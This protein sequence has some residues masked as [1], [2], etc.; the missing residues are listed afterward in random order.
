[1]DGLLL[2]SILLLQE[3]AN[4]AVADG[5]RIEAHV[6]FGGHVGAD[7]FTELSVR[8]FSASGGDLTL[9]ANGDS[10]NVSMEMRLPAGESTEV[11]MPLAVAAARPSPALHAALGSRAPVTVAL[12]ASSSVTSPIPSPS[13]IDAFTGALSV[14]TN[15]SSPSTTSS[16]RTGTTNGFEVSPAPNT[17]TVGPTG[18]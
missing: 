4:P 2:V 13:V 6:A 3:T 15:C 11:R 9:T 12:N 17:S 1:M 18:M 7:G 14:T 8:T 5:M 16:P 10:P